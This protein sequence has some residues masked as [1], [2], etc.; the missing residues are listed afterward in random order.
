MQV[1]NPTLIPGASRIFLRTSQSMMT[2]FKAIIFDVDG[3]LSE[4]EEIH[5]RAFNETF[6]Y[7]GFDWHWTQGRY[8][9]LLLVSG[10]KERIR[11]FLDHALTPH[12]ETLDAL[13]EEP[14][15]CR[16]AGERPTRFHHGRPCL[17]TVS[18]NHI[19]AQ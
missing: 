18:Q 19:G 6:D 3:T 17:I 12:A 8:R 11:H 13:V 4:T 14:K 16:F 5:R 7:F 15:F 9:E 1:S 10:G 2:P